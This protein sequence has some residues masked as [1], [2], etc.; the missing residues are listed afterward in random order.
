MA[1]AVAPLLRGLLFGVSPR[2]PVSLGL[3]AGILMLAALAAAYVPARQVLK[4]DVVNALR[5]D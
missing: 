3:A 4:L 1:C 5:A 2:D